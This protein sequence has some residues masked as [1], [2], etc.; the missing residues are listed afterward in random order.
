MVHPPQRR[1]S[2]DREAIIRNAA[3]AGLRVEIEEEPPVLIDVWPDHW[4]LIPVARR[5]S[6]QLNVSMGG[7]V[8]WRHES[9]PHTFRML[10]I[11][12]ARQREISDD[13]HDLEAAIVAELNRGAKS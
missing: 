1:T 5:M 13:L 7:V 2:A 9:L 8:G 4:E 3:A 12:L 6:T 10:D 11:P